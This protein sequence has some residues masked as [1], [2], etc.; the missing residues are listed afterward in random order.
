MIRRLTAGLALMMLLAAVPTMADSIV[1][2]ATANW[3]AFP[4]PSNLNE[5]GTPFWDNRSMDGS[6]KNVGYFLTNTGAF[7]GGTAGPGPLSFWGFANGTADTNV[8]FSSN[9]PGNLAQIM[10]EIAGYANINAFGWY[11]AANPSV[12]HPLFPGPAN[13][14][15]APVTF[16]PSTNYGFYIQV[17]TGPVFYTQSSLNAGTQ[18]QNHQHFAVFTSSTTSPHPTYWIGM[19]D[20]KLSST[21]IECYGD[22]NDMVVRI[23]PVPIPEPASLTLMGTGLLVLAGYVRRRVKS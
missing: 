7:T 21:G 8:Y 14:G 12:L 13:S 22:F 16:T 20:L 23:T 17:G 19:E 1:G 18:E 5:N 3:Q 2:A 4:T 10:V 15:S 9:T 11:D 6:Q